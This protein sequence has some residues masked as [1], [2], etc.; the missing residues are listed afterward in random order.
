MNVYIVMGNYLVP[1]EI[2]N[3]YIVAVFDNKLNA[4]RMLRKLKEAIRNKNADLLR[5]IDPVGKITES[6]SNSVQRYYIE[7]K[8]VRSKSPC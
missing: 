5:S 4:Q 7:E 8:D 2:E 6:Y 3:T 1:Y